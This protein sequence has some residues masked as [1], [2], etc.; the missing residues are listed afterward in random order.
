MLPFL[1]DRDPVRTGRKTDT[2]EITQGPC[3][4]DNFIFLSCFCLPDDGVQSIIQE[5]RIDLGLK[6]TKF[7]LSE[8]LFVLTTLLH[9]LLQTIR[10]GIDR[11]RKVSELRN[12]CLIQSRIQITF[13]KLA[14]YF[15]QPV[16]GLFYKG[17][18]MLH[19]TVS[20]HPCKNDHDP[21]TDSGNQD[22]K[23]KC[24]TSFSRRLDLLGD[25]LVQHTVH[26]TCHAADFIQHLFIFHNGTPLFYIVPDLIYII[27]QCL[28]RTIGDHEGQAVLL[29][30]LLHDLTQGFMN[31]PD[32]RIHPASRHRLPAADDSPDTF[33]D[34]HGN[35]VLQVGDGLH[36]LDGTM[37][38]PC[39]QQHENKAEKDRKNQQDHQFLAHA[40]DLAD[41]AFFLSDLYHTFPN[42]LQPRACRY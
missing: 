23:L 37:V 8:I 6:G 26:Q 40:V 34:L 39:I 13:R 14:R 25:I 41:D 22:Q 1:I 28:H 21:F 11:K 4:L 15:L 18:R 33:R 9:H 10:H 3:Q 30:R 16:N 27:F 12:L 38:T 36:T 29:I 42:T 19:G 31:L 17:R 2:E 24:R 5:M 20:E 32:R 35:N 7:R